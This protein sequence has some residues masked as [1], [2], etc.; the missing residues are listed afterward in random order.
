MRSESLYGEPGGFSIQDELELNEQLEEKPQL[1]TQFNEVK[2]SGKRHQFA[3][4]AVRDIQEGK[5]MP[6]LLPS[7]ALKRLSKHFENGAKKYSPNNW[8]KGILLSAFLDSAFRHWCD[9]RDCLHDEDHMAA[10]MWNAACFMETAEMIKQGKLPKEL[11]DIGWFQS[12]E[13]ETK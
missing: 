12:Q 10:L 7:H 8:R 5:G 1:E 11:D 6:H 3:T 2:D 13:E 4:G 9:A